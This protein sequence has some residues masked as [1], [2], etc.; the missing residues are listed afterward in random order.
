MRGDGAGRE[1]LGIEAEAEDA[2]GGSR[3][4]GGSEMVT[5]K[6]TGVGVG[7]RIHPETAR[8]SG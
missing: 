5:K 4:S 1:K 6:R 3:E 8:T 7:D 2:S